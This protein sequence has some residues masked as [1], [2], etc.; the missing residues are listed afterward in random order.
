MRDEVLAFKR[1]RILQEAILHF[2]Q[3]GFSGTTLDD[4]AQGLGVT[5]PFIYAHFKSKTDLLTA[6]CLPMIEMTVA[7]AAKTAKGPGTAT[8]RLRR[9][10]ADHMKAVLDHQA[11]IAIYFRDE[12][13]LPVMVRSEIN[14]LRKKFDR[15]L[16]KL[17]QEGVAAGEFELPDVHLAA[18]AM[19]GMI[20]WAYTWHR[21]TGR[22]SVDELC[23]RMSALALQMAG[24]RAAKAGRHARE[25]K[26][27]A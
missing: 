3:R 12:R 2:D 18:L 22:L 26:V 14:G 10:I 25:A 1:E 13:S 5:K 15:V 6:I 11:S 23:S 8:D 19:G 7:G 9:V 27:S 4:I 17:L 24:A 20:S 16:S 21:P